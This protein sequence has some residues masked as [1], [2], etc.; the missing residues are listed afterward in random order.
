M[1]VDKLVET[2]ESVCRNEVDKHYLRICNEDLSANFLRHL[3]ARLE[4]YIPPRLLSELNDYV[5]E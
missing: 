1:R 4:N 3:E 5:K 2:V